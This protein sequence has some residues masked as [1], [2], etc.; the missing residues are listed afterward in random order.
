MHNN[1]FWLPINVG[2]TPVDTET[3]LVIAPLPGK[4]P[5]SFGIETSLFVEINVAP[6]RTPNVAVA[7]FS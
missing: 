3:T 5:R 4:K 1:W 7:N 2:W 6:L